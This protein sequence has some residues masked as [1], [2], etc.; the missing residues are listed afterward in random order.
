MIRKLNAKGEALLHQNIPAEDLPAGYEPPDENVWKYVGPN[1]RLRASHR[2]VTQEQLP[3]LTA[4]EISKR[5]SEAYVYHPHTTAE[6]LS[7]GEVV[8][9]EISLWPGGMVFDAG[10]SMRFEVKGRL[11]VLV[12][13]KPLLD[14][15]VNYNKGEHIL[16]TGG[17]TSSQLSVYLKS[18]QS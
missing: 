18:G 9:L 16:H 14:T 4:E 17:A 2:E 3:G 1:G 13:F 10:E 11:P 7:P 8:K 15:L 12:E 6:K 5:M